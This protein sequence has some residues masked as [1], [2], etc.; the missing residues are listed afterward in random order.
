MTNNM[1]VRPTRLADLV[2]TDVVRALFTALTDV[3][4]LTSLLLHGGP[5]VGKTSAIEC[6]CIELERRNP[7]FRKNRDVLTLNASD[8]RGL[9]TVRS[10]VA[11]FVRHGGDTP[12]ILVLDEIDAMTLSAQRTLATVMCNHNAVLFCTCNYL[13]RVD[14]ALRDMCVM[15]QMPAPD[16]GQAIQRL[17]VQTGVDRVVAEGVYTESGGDLRA[18]RNYCGLMR[19]LPTDTKFLTP[20]QW[21][22]M[23]MTETCKSRAKVLMSNR[24]MRHEL[25]ALLTTLHVPTEY[26]TNALRELMDVTI[27]QIDG[28]TNDAIGQSCA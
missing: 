21:L 26:R 2:L 14:M 27:G 6:I 17:V 11:A 18:A 7:Q 4:N 1:D 13:C 8:D 19:V 12:K 25:E 16:H 28:E 5:G 22:N 3:P 10:T 23:E 20:E 24:A 9:E 15:V